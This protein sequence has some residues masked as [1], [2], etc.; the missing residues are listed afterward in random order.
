MSGD[1]I[2]IGVSNLERGRGLIEAFQVIGNSDSDE[3]ERNKLGPSL[4]E[5][6]SP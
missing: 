4:R 1:I 5:F 6:F 2:G 3:W